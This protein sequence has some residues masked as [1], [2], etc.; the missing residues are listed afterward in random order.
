MSSAEEGPTRVGEATAAGC[1]AEDYSKGYVCDGD[2][3]LCPRCADAGQASPATSGTR[4]QSL[5]HLKTCSS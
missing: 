1:G 4:G 3:L 2:P 5:P